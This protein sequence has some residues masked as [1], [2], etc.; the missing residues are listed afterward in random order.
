MR[1][2]I[3]LTLVLL[4][5]GCPSRGPVLPPTAPACDNFCST[6]AFY[7]CEESKPARRDRTCVE[8]CVTIEKSGYMTIDPDCVVRHSGSLAAIRTECN[9][10]CIEGKP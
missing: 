9:V 3:L 8:R 7:S 10:K 4:Q 1:R 6:L 2:L 5:T